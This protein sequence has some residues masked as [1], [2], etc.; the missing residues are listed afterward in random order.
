MPSFSMAQFLGGLAFFAFG[1]HAMREG[2]QLLAGDRLRQR[3]YRLTDNRFKSF[4]FGVLLTLILQSSGAATALLVSFADTQLVTLRQAFGVILGADVGTTVVVF[5]LAAK[6]ITEI[7]M[8]AMVVGFA[9][10]LVATR[11]KFRYFGSILFGFG[12][13][14]YGIHLLVETM[15]PLH[16]GPVAA[17][18]LRFLSSQPF[19]SF[20]LALGFAALVHSSAA[21]IGLVLSL[22]FAGLVTM[23]GALPLVLGANVGSCITSV[24]AS[25]GRD[26]NARR[27]AVAHL[28]IKIAGAAIAWPLLPWAAR[29]IRATAVGLEGFAYPFN[30]LVGLQIALAHIG[31]N[32]GL[33]MIFLPLL[34]FGVWIVIRLVPEP[35]SAR[36]VFAPKYLDPKAIETPAIAFAQARREVMRLANIALDL[37]RD[38]LKLF[39]RSHEFAEVV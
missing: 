7:A 36:E 4:G 39:D 10:H 32:A 5:L 16:N 1:L 22:A 9:L 3:I 12:L 17:T 2:L 8:Y 34:P 29:W 25:I 13:V 19:W 18:L 26:V 14:F 21:T 23:E 15:L 38:G 11:R 30:G 28:F 37:Y 35:E 24:R 27:V 6:R 20:C 31:F 33:A